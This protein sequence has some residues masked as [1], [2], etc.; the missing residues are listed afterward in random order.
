MWKFPRGAVVNNLPANAG[1]MRDNGSVP[2]LRRFPKGGNGYPL[3]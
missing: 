3:Q 1:D 2:E